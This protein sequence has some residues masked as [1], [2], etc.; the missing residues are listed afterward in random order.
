MRKAA[1]LSTVTYLCASLL[2]FIAAAFVISAFFAPTATT[3]EVASQTMAMSLYPSE[4]D[5]EALPKEKGKGV[6]VETAR[7]ITPDLVTV[8]TYPFTSSAAVA[9]EDM[10]SGTTQLVAAGSDDGNST[11]Q[12]IGFDFW[13]DGVRFTQFGVNAN[14]FAS[15]GIAPTGLSFT[16]SIA[17]ITNAPKIMPY[18][19]DLWVG[20]NGNVRFKVVG[21][22]GSRKLV[23]E[24]NNMTIPRA[25]AATT[26]AGTFQLWLYESSHPTLGGVIQFVYGSGIIINSANSGYSV[27]LQSGAATNFASVTTS[28]PTVSY[29][30]ANNTQTNA[31]TS[32]TAYTFTPNV[33][34]APT[35]LNFTAV[36]AT[37]MTLNWTDNASNEAGYAIYQ[38]TDGIN[39]SFAT[40]AAANA[41][42]QAISGLNPSTTY[43]FQVYAVSEGA[44]S[45]ALSGSQATAPPGNISSTAAGGNWSAAATWVGGVVPT[46]GDNVTIVSGATVTIDSSNALNLTVQ[47]GGTLQ[48]EATTARTLTVGQ[49]VT[50]D[51]GG[52]FQSAATG[53]QT[54]HVL[55]VGT[56]LTN[57]GTLDFSTNGNTAGARITFTGA[58]NNTFS[59]TGAT[60]DIRT[61]TVNKG[62]SNANVVEITTSNLTVQGVNTDVAGFLTLTNGTLKIS[63]T[64]TM[65]NRVFTTAAYTI[66]ATAGIWLNNPNFTVA[67]TASSTTSGNNGLL[68]LTQGTYTI[69]LTGADGFQVAA[70][71]SVFIIEGG[72]LNANGRFDPQAGVSYTQTGGTVNCAIVGNTASAFGSFEIFGTTGSFTMSAGTINLINPNVT[73][74]TKHDYGMNTLT[75]NITGGQVIFGATGAPA[76]SSYNISFGA[77]FLPNFTVNPTMTLNVNNVRVLCRGTAITNNG[78]IISTGTSALFDFANAATSTSYGGP[79]TFGTLAA[80]FAAISAN[81]PGFHVLSS[82][83]VTLRVNLFTGGFTNSN[84]ITLGNAGTSTTVVQTGSAGLLTPGGS[85]DV[86]PVHNQGSGGQ[87]IL[88][89][90]ESVLR[91]TGL[92]VNPTRSL[93]I[94]SV[95]TTNNVSIAGGDLTCTSVAASPNNALTLTTGRVITNANTLIL[96]NA[97]SAVVRTTGYVDGNFRKN[98]SAVASKSF[99]VGTANGFSPVTVNV[100]AGTFP[101]D[102]TVKAVQGPHPNFASPQYA[103]QRYWSLSTAATLTA[104]LTFNYLDPTDIPVTANENVF[105]IFKYTG[106]FTTPGGTVTPATN[107]ATI[108]GVTSFSDWTLGQPNA[109]TAGSSRISGVVTR[110]DGQPLGGVTINLSGSE[111]GR[112]ITDGNGSYRFNNVESNGFYTV[113]PDLIDYNFSPSSRSFSLIG[114]RTDAVFTGTRESNPRGNPLTGPDFFVRQQYLDFLGREPDMRGWL[115][116]TD[117]L[118]ACG[119]DVNCVR[120]KRIDISAAFFRSAEYQEG[121]NF[122]YRLYRAGLGRTL[123]YDEFNTDRQQVVGGPE[124]EHS[125]RVFADSFVRRAEFMQKYD[126]ID[127]GPTFVDALLQSTRL[128]AGVELGAQREALL[129]AYHAGADREQSRSA[130]LQAVAE[131]SDYQRA[132]YNHSFVVTQYFGYLRRSPDADGLSFWVEILN[133]RDSGNYRGM[134]CSFL[135]SAEYQLRFSSVV[136]NSNAECGAQIQ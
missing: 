70:A 96:P 13:Y 47:S 41:T 4:R 53:T 111:S 10:S 29:A 76:S 95:T 20:T 52:V 11:L 67:G 112:T 106:V 28:G 3:Q 27:G 7:P 91:T 17:T 98:Y 64:F 94:L 129:A 72:T 78:A 60:T 133:Q 124:L 69:G 74:G 128:D 79:G 107:T 86:S 68:R 37:G 48:F 121:G 57:N 119:A 84:Q 22:T 63:G 100:T 8:T 108:T 71:S 114:D 99:E 21:A 120:Q 85:F 44:L 65:T 42:S 89:N 59:G 104:D 126:G 46:T 45:T 24:W 39:Y 61:I 109:P 83:I 115:F 56:N 130:V 73:A 25:G 26:G 36:T 31:I 66:P 23:V 62:T 125:R 136:I 30:A 113:T 34:A 127:S 135:T 116:W 132:V 88:Y 131:A 110:S 122:V 117:Q 87:I 19:D 14:G 54:G 75:Q 93:T 81:S 105:V 5:E 80:P 50:I 51:A 2:T 101:A 38:S 15:L 40:Q 1:N 6:V 32:G 134:V 55:S 18:W 90:Q 16:N 58:A 49:S 12:N 77:A 35:G 92:E 9:L 97:A 82:P 103:L 102:F 33:P 123:T 43:F 118:Y